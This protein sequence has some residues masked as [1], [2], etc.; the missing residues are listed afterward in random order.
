MSLEA[1][2]QNKA[3]S[4]FWFRFREMRVMMIINILI[5]I[6][7]YP[8][9]S[10]I[11][12]RFSGHTHDELSLILDIGILVVVTPFIAFATLLMAYIG[13]LVSFNF[14]H[15]GNIRDMHLALPLTHRQRFF[16]SLSA[17]AGI[18]ILPYIASSLLGLFIFRVFSNK[19][20]L[21][22]LFNPGYVYGDAAY[23]DKL[24]INAMVA[25]YILPVMFTG[26]M[27]MLFIFALTI[28]CNMICGK[29]LTAGFFPFLY[30][31]VVPLL[32]VSLSSL[33]MYNAWGMY[34]LGN[35]P[36]IISSPLGMLFGSFSLIVDH[37]MFTVVH[38]MYLIPALA[39]IAGMFTGAFYL[40][41]NAKAENIGRDFLYKNIYNV[42]QALV[43]LTVVALFG[44]LFV[45]VPHGI[46]V[47]LA[48][49]VSFVLFFI[50]HVIHYK[51][52]SKL[53]K[54]AITYGIIA[55]SALALCAIL[56]FGQGFGAI[57]RVPA[58][59][60]IDAVR[61]TAFSPVG[62]SM[63]N[64]PNSPFSGMNSWEYRRESDFSQEYWN[65]ITAEARRI[66]R[67]LI[68]NP[69]PSR[70]QRTG[71]W[72]RD[73]YTVEIEYVLKNGLTVSRRYEY[74]PEGIDILAERGILRSPGGGGFGD[75]FGEPDWED[76]STEE[77][78]FMEWLME[79]ME[80]QNNQ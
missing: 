45:N 4:Y 59:R 7:S 49:F 58:A 31:A 48:I 65:E 70:G 60:D 20:N 30:S 24:T 8:L 66:H 3:V 25:E 35:F 12:A 38:P 42:Q 61:I 63:V 2:K 21:E 67:V 68:D 33:V 44:W 39:V 13:A 32:I 79:M 78:E 71:E 54:G 29:F 10:I 43:C 62:V 11:A 19:Q 69:C 1:K 18:T 5:G 73:S 41:K 51:G 55:G 16:A 26:L 76:M 74:T 56:V 22:E 40:S 23:A 52:L 46:I 17:G 53:K 36:Y 57:G 15:N 75:G 64:E 34:T 14:M 6:M 50:G 9:L 37:S 27:V 77:R 28:F 47:F 72:W 80:E